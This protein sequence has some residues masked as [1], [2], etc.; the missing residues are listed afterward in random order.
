MSFTGASL[1]HYRHLQ[2]LV[3]AGVAVA[4]AVLA[5]ALLVGTSVRA[6]LRDL[7]LQRLGTTDL[8][9]STSTSFGSRLGAAMV[10]AAPDAVGQTTSLIAV[11][12]TV[13]HATSGRIA[14]GVQVYGVDDTFWTFHGVAPVPLSGREAAVSERLAAEL[15]AADTDALIIRASGP[16]DI[17][18][19]TLQGR[20]DNAGARIRVTKVRTLEASAHGRVRPAARAR[21]RR[22][23]VRASLAAAAGTADPRP[24]EHDSGAAHEAGGGVGARP[25]TGRGRADGLAGRRCLARPRR[26]HPPRPR[27][28]RHGARRPRGLHQ[29]RRRGARAGRPESR[30]A[31]RRPGAHLRRQRD[32]HRG[33]GHPVLDGDRD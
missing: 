19:A 5:G 6:S 22:R 25:R 30:A 3:G 2:L 8:A 33:S 24:G 4:V 31:S 15:G 21:A 27:R 12:G 9:I 17:P 23:R 29:R 14:A 16:S 7:A 13:S 1:W 26:A 18:L 20:R 28:S 32:S 11:A 10:I